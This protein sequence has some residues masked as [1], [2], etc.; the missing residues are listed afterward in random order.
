MNTWI[1]GEKIDQHEQTVVSPMTILKRKKRQ[2]TSIRW[3]V[4]LPQPD[5]LCPKRPSNGE[6]S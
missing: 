4:V 6:K 2:T 5:S 3:L 1:H